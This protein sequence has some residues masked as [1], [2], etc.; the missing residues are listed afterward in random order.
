MSPHS[1]RDQLTARMAELRETVAAASAELDTLARAVFDMDV[2]A[3][4]KQPRPDPNAS[5]NAVQAHLAA[6]RERREKR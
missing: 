4:R 5:Q 2:A 3:Q 6:L 1:T